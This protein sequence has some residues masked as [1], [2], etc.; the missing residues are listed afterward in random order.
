MLSWLIFNFPVNCKLISNGI[1]RC[2][3]GGNNNKSLYLPST[4]R[5]RYLFLIDVKCKA[6]IEIRCNDIGA[7]EAARQCYLGIQTWRPP[8]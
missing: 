3:A 6:N 4:P 8:A 7:F 2:Y 5:L 1:T